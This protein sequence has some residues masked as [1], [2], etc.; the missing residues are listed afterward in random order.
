MRLTD[1]DTQVLAARNG[2]PQMTLHRFGKGC[3]AYLSG[4]SY[5]A[6]AARML[7]DLLLY[8]TGK[9]GRSAGYCDNPM[10]E[11]TWFP[12]SNTLVVMN[13]SDNRVST[14]VEWPGGGDRI[15]LEPQ[16]M[17]FIVY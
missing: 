12:V 8:M 13:N 9:D 11:T 15:T 10:V 3:A 16:E 6:E 4:F 7:L 1:P 14:Q 2:A 5:S 17:R